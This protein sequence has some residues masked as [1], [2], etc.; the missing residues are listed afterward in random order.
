[1]LISTFSP[2][3]TLGEAERIQS[4]ELFKTPFL[5]PKLEHDDQGCK[6]TK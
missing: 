3:S 4:E 1:M 2:F 6:V 5:H